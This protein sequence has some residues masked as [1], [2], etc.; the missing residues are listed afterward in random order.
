MSSNLQGV[1]FGGGNDYVGFWV[2][3]DDQPFGEGSTELPARRALFQMAK[4]DA[5]VPETIEVP[6]GVPFLHGVL[7]DQDGVSA[8]AGLSIEIED[9]S[10]TVIDTPTPITSDGSVIQTDAEGSI[11]G[12]LI[13]SPAAGTWTVKIKGDTS[14]E[15][16]FQ[17]F[18]ATFP[19]AD[20]ETT[21]EQ[22]IESAFGDVLDLDE[23]RRYFGPEASWGCIACTIGVYTLAVLI[24]AAVVVGVAVLTEGSAVVV[25]VAAWSG[26]TT[27]ASLAFVRGL[28]AVV[29]LGVGAVAG[30]LCGWVGA[31][32]GDAERVAGRYGGASAS[33]S[34]A[35]VTVTFNNPAGY[36]G[37]LRIVG[38]DDEGGSGLVF[39]AGAGSGQPLT[40]VVSGWVSYAARFIPTGV[41]TSPRGSGDA[42]FSLIFA[43]DE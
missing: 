13:P 29:S 43:A 6:A 17:L 39:S 38:Y 22:A 1:S 42:T 16:S 26:A 8:P 18:V 40:A 7:T 3:N 24:I 28:V 5:S 2:G 36:Q 12:F 37:E 23:V 11:I 34:S 21:I 35:P 15:P 32:S 27:A 31:C 25:A 10:G 14:G 41:L 33:D 9:P 20:D 30:N 19:T 4:K